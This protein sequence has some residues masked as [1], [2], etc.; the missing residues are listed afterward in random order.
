MN[1]WNNPN[2][3][4]DKLLQYYH[5]V[6]QRYNINNPSDS[7]KLSKAN[8]ENIILH[9]NQSAIDKLEEQNR[10][11]NRKIERQLLMEI[12]GQK[13]I[14]KNKDQEFYD[15]K[16]FSEVDPK[17]SQQLSLKKFVNFKEAK[18]FPNLKK[19]PVY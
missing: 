6:N 15:L 8:E 17:L 4:P 13:L 2:R 10:M 14:K 7:E 1:F 3:I 5:I 19:D 12:S 18:R 9:H 16:A 11:E